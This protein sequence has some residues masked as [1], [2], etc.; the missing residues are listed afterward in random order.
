V[1]FITIFKLAKEYRKISNKLS[2]H[3]HIKGNEN[4]KRTTP[5]TDYDRSETPEICEIFY[6]FGY[7]DNK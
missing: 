3:E 7:H 6:L 5:I 1:T 4:L 2:G